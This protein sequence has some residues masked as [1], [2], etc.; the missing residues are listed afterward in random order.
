MKEWIFP[1]NEDPFGSV[2]KSSLFVISIF[3][4]V[5]LSESLSVC[6]FFAGGEDGEVRPDRLWFGERDLDL[7]IC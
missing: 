4:S 7:E 5:S 2:E 6:V 1:V 3:F